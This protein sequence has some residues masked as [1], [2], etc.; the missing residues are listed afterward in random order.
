MGA[1]VGADWHVPAL[2]AIAPE[3]LNALTRHCHPLLGRTF[4]IEPCLPIEPHP[5]L[6]QWVLAGMPKLL[7]EQLKLLDALNLLH[8][9]MGSRSAELTLFEALA[10]ALDLLAE[11]HAHFLHGTLIHSGCHPGTG[12]VRSKSLVQ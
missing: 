5:A 6:L 10:G 9:Q 2:R 11:Q 8:P 1:V 12:S 7:V 3:S 4:A